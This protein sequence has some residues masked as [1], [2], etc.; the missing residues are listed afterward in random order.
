M[1]RRVLRRRTPVWRRWCALLHCS[2]PALQRP[3]RVPSTSSSNTQKEE[4]AAAAAAGAGQPNATW[5]G[6]ARAR[7]AEL[8][9]HQQVLSVMASTSVMMSGHGVLTPVLP[10]FAD[11]LG[12][13]TAQLGMSLSAFAVARLVLNVPLGIAADRYGRRLLLVAGPLVNAVGMGGSVLSGSVEELLLWRLLAGA[14]NAAYLGG[15]SMYL[16][17]IATKVRTLDVLVRDG[18]SSGSNSSNSSC[19]SCS[20]SSSTTS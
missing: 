2:A 15:A 14:G 4:A 8:R 3:P 6:Q 17:D 1:L 18:G 20:C 11:T 19:C 10:L 16:N 7:W 13:T 12:A 5:A 9:Q